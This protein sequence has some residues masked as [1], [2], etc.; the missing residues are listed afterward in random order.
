M[1][2]PSRHRVYRNVITE[3]FA[4]NHRLLIQRTDVDT[5]LFKMGNSAFVRSIG[6]AFVPSMVVGDH[7][8]EQ[9]FWFHVLSK[10]PSPLIMGMEFIR[11]IQLYTKNK[12]LL[13]DCPSLCK[14]PTLKWIG[15]PQSQL[16]FVADGK[17]LTGHVDTGSDLDLMSLRCATIQGFKIDTFNTCDIIDGQYPYNVFSL[18]TLINL[19]PIQTFINRKLRSKKNKAR[20]DDHDLALEVEHYR[21]SKAIRLIS[22]I[23]DETKREAAVAEEDVKRKDFDRRHG[24][25]QRCN[26]VVPESE[27][28]R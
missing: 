11:R 20:M 7:E 25:C 28:L 15:A 18:N 22:K 19:G 6:R 5:G 26:G 21:R 1:R 16:D 10:C 8:S 23:G 12:H 3:E 4:N 2:C 17:R 14:I 13:I 27:I 9:G 24:N